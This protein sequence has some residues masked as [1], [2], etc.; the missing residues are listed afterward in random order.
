M[1]VA[2]FRTYYQRCGCHPY[3]IIRTPGEATHRVLT[4]EEVA[5]LN[6]DMYGVPDTE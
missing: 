2:R 4:R 3:C 5:L 1:A 6:I